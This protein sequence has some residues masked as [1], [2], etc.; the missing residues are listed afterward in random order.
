MAKIQKSKWIKQCPD[1]NN[2]QYY[3]NKWDLNRAIGDNKKCISCAQKGKT[4]WNKGLDKS[5]PRVQKYIHKVGEFQHTEE[6]KELLRNKVLGKTY[7]EIM[8]VE[9]SLKTKQKH[10]KRTLKRMDTHK[11]FFNDLACEY[12]DWLNKMNDWDGQHALNGGEKQVCGYFVDYYEPEHNIVIEWDEPYHHKKK[13]VFTKDRI[14]EQEILKELNCD[15]YR[16]NQETFERNKVIKC[17]ELLT[18]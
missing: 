14:R 18:A 15:F 10:R 13:S 9:K 5:D 17:E 1:C 16:I 12:F 7:E 6:T 2:I 8:G 4:P 3:C 11:I